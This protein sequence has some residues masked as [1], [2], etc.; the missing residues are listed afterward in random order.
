[1]VLAGCVAPSRGAD[2]RFPV[3]ANFTEGLLRMFADPHGPPLGANDWS[4]RPTA[5]HPQPVILV[6]G[7]FGNMANS[8]QAMAPALANEGYCVFALNYGKDSPWGLFGGLA[9]MEISALREFGPF[10]DRVLVATGARQVDVI[11]HSQGAVMPRFWMRNGPSVG[12]D[13]TPKIRTLV[14]IASANGGTTFYGL[15][16]LANIFFGDR[17]IG[18]CGACTQFFPASPSLVALRDPAVRPGQRFGGDRQPGVRYVM[19]GTR[20]DNIVVPYRSSFL[21]GATNIVIQDVCSLDH[22]DHLGMVYDPITV[23]LVLNELSPHDARSPACR[24]VP[25]VFPIGHLSGD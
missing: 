25:P 6:H 13:G 15:L 24:W 10:V 1:M 11:G 5:K 21:D 22:S 4:C 9:P 18:T 20:F 8:W 17:P 2:G 16:T 12:P 3:A 23:Q 7:T 19:L 14:G